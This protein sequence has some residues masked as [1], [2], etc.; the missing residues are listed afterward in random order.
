MKYPDEMARLEELLR[1][2][3]PEMYREVED[4]LE[5]LLAR[6]SRPPQAR[7]TLAWRGALCY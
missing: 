4:F 5:L 2:L 3:P 7:P 6:K 1:E